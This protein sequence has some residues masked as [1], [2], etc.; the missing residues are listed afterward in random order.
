MQIKTK[1]RHHLMPVKKAI[2]TKIYKQDM[3]E[4]C[5]E[6]G[7]LLH[8]WWKRKLIQSLQIRV[9]RFLRKRPH[10]PT[11]PL[12]GLYPEKV[13]VQKDSCTPMFIAALFTTAWT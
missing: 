3:L 5:R 8:S 7:T 4:K 13:I 10:D 12:L 6:E 2:I 9:W 11:I 1:M